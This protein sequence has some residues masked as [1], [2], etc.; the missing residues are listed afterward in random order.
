MFRL[1]LVFIEIA[2]HRCG[3]ERLPVS[4]FLFG[5]LTVIYLFASIVATQ[6]AE[7]LSRAAAMVVFDTALYLG[8]IS[9]L[10]TAYSYPGRFYQT[11][12]AIFGAQTFLTLIGIP[13]LLSIGIENGEIE[14]PGAGTWLFL[15]LI[16]WSIDIAGFVLSRALQI[17]YF[18]GVLIV[19]GYSFGSYTLG[20][21]LFPVAG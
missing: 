6:I 4:R 20:G 2:F 21:L 19:L 10:L 17:S 1:G 12:T 9:L 7:P 14:V 11:V 13:F 5:L 15:M 18:L 16:L 8:F 3:P